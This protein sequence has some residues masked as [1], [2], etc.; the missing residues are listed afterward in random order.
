MFVSCI[1]KSKER[2]WSPDSWPNVGSFYRKPWIC[3]DIQ[4][5]IQ[6][7]DTYGR[8]KSTYIAQPMELAVDNV[9]HRPPTQV[10]LRDQV[11]LAF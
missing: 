3:R 7:R 2:T 1:I 11:Y 5:Q 8:K 9:D 10:R 4:I 6:S